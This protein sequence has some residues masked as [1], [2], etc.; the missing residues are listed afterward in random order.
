MS[1]ATRARRPR[2]S[3]QELRELLVGA[4]IALLEEEGLGIGAGGLTFKRVFDHV[5]STSGVRLTN[6][7]VIRRV[8]LNQEDFRTDV[9]TT[10]AS[11]ADSSGELDRTLEV[12]APL[13]ESMDRSTPEARLRSLAQAARIGGEAGIRARVETREWSLWVGVWVLAVTTT[14]PDRGRRIREALDAG[15]VAVAGL[16]EQVFTGISDYLGLRLRSPLTVHQFTVAVGGMIEGIALRQG[17]DPDLEVIELPT[18]PD[19]RPE[20]WT[21]A[22]VCLDALARRFFEIDPDWDPG[23]EPGTG[24]ERG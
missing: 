18:G 2:H 11:T 20:E 21:L 12:M 19:G 15:L 16:W 6:A 9:L 17:G 23:P 7:S 14:D 8:W 3:R 4:G 22:G 13:L 10:I 5:E 1:E 24:E